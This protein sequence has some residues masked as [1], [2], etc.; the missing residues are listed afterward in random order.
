MTTK[1]L[2]HLHALELGLF[3]E[4]KLLKTAKSNKERELR[5]VW[6]QQTEKEIAGELEFLGLEPHD[7]ISDKSDADILADLGL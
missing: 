4:K 5:E 2:S 1:D 6:I 3:I 7:D